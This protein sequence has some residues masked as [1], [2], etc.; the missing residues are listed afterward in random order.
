MRRA[1]VRL[2]PQI[3]HRFKDAY[4][5][6][7]DKDQA[8][9]DLISH[10]TLLALNHPKNKINVRILFGKQLDEQTNDQRC[11]TDQ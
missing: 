6:V 2:V 4:Q 9:K 8:R 7:V 11:L 5:A 10:L 1:S 3:D